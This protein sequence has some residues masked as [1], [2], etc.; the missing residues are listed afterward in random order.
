MQVYIKKF[1]W[2]NFL[3]ENSSTM[4]GSVFTF[5]WAQINM[6]PFWIS[7]W[8]V[9][10]SH[11]T[12]ITPHLI[13]GFFYRDLQISTMTIITRSEAHFWFIILFMHASPRQTMC[14]QLCKTLATSVADSHPPTQW[15]E[16][17]YTLNN[18]TY[19]ASTVYYKKYFSSPN[20]ENLKWS[21]KEHRP[22]IVHKVIAICRSRSRSGNL[23][24]P[25]QGPWSSVSF[26]QS[27]CSWWLWALGSCLRKQPIRR[28]LMRV[29]AGPVFEGK[30]EQGD[31]SVLC[32]S[33]QELTKYW[34]FD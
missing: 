9:D 20:L 2:I 14:F 10:I 18:S 13:K 31:G 30:M 11:K 23:Q 25:V 27:L 19:A 28:H 29:S 17:L 6:L 32:N 26:F 1:C 12:F 4:R 5:L 33:V 16:L 24:S 8:K 34:L 21:F 22:C 3:Q 15:G 7:L